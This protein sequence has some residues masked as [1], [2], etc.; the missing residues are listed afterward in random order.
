MLITILSKILGFGR[1]I[2]LSYIYGASGISDAY[3]IAIAIPGVVFGFIAA[4]LGAG[5]IPLY[6]KILQNEG[7]GQANKF[8][9]NLINVLLIISMITVTIGLLFTDLIVRIFASG[10]E[11]E[12]FILAVKFTKISLLAIFFTAIVS[13][14]SEFLQMKGNFYIPAL[15]GIPLNLFIIVAIVASQYVDVSWMT[16]GYVIAV[17]SQILLMLPFLQKKKYRYKPLLH[18]ND[19]NMIQMA[20]IVL[21]LIIGVLI[22][23]VNTLVFKNIASQTAVGGVSSLNYAYILNTF[24]QGVFVSSIAMVLYPTLAKMAA[25]KN[26]GG[27]K[28]I[29]SVSITDINLLVIPATVGAMVFNTPIVRILYARGAFGND[30]IAMTSSALLFYSVGMIGFGLR[31]VMSRAFYSLHDVKTPMITTA[32]GMLLNILLSLILSKYLGIGGLALGTSIS[33]IFTVVLMFL[34]MR[35]KIGP[36]GMNK[37]VISFFKIL[38]ASLVMGGA[39]KIAY[40]FLVARLSSNLSLIIAIGIGAVIYF[41]IVYFM[42]IDGVDSMI[43][44]IK[45]KLGRGSV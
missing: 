21:P 39:A 43:R 6:S 10:F 14:F 7:E 17:I 23:Q 42:K 31:D 5:Y 22:E 3:L 12:T 40:D 19:P 28:G 45:V 11:G 26:I 38:S 1:E 30:A 29:L 15:V 44:A 25:E 20:Y 41:A 13:T 34:F 8:T 35:K 2:T 16:A 24:I 33:A 32:A 27:F 4:G 18:L 37:A 36:F 9:S